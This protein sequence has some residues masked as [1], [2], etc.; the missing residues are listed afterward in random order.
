MHPQ[1]PRGWPAR[2]L[3]G[4]LALVGSR[5]PD[6]STSRVDC[7]RQAW[8]PGRTRR[9]GREKSRKRWCP[10]DCSRAGE[11]HSIQSLERVGRR[12]RRATPTG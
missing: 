1:R 7:R 10:E 6:G 11:A 12:L 2:T 3:P 4:S 9:P 5:A 8:Q